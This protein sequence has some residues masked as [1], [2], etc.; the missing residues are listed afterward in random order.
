MGKCKNC[1]GETK[2]NNI[3]C[4]LKCRNI[5]V[6]KNLRD[7]KKNIESRKVNI[8]ISKK[9]KE[10]EYNK[11]PKYCKYCGEKISFEKKSNDFCNSSCSASYTNKNRKGIKYNLTKEGKK[12]LQ[13]SLNKNK[14]LS[15]KKIKEMKKEYYSNVKRC[16]NCGKMLPFNKRKNVFCDIKCKSDFA[17][18]NKTKKEQYKFETKFNFS[19]KE[20][21]NEFDFNL[22]EKYGWYSPS[23]SNKPNLNGVSR[24]HMLSVIDGF[25]Q[26]IEPKLL[27]HPA[28][29][30]LMLHTK[31][32]SKN[33][34][35]SI[36]LDE[37]LKRID[38]WDKR[39]NKKMGI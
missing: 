5:Y 4:S 12:A 36:T 10:K 28:N 6:N 3:Y 7:Y 21:P 24:D 14:G 27:S 13:K 1:G 17:K 39:Y 20:Y 23:N 33:S 2:K 15:D 9:K 35:S 38:E 8:E 31:N 29:C 16:K 37:L 30:K 32:I 26:G 11:K 34:K 19:L 18:K 25:K 22:I